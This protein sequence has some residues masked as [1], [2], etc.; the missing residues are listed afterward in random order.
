MRFLADENLKAPIVAELLYLTK[1]EASQVPKGV[2]QNQ[3]YHLPTNSLRQTEV[4]VTE[5]LSVKVSD[6][7]FYSEVVRLLK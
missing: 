3:F 1:Y 5:A 4:R 7:N 6:I 2:E